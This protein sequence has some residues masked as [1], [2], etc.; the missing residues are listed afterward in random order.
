M[1]RSTAW[2]LALPAGM[3]AAGAA[4]GTA[5]LR[6]GTFREP[7]LAGLLAVAVVLACGFA[8]QMYRR[9]MPRA[10]LAGG[11]GAGC[12]IL[13]FFGAPIALAWNG[14]VDAAAA[15]LFIVLLPLVAAGTAAGGTAYLARGVDRYRAQHGMAHAPR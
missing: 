2:T 11:L 8:L 6:L 4:V 15:L 13:G 10:V 1:D 5:W 9:G 12:A 14:G 3:A 7:Q